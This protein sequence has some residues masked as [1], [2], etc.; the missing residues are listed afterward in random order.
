MASTHYS[1]RFFTNQTNAYR[2]H[3]RAKKTNI[4]IHICIT[5]LHP[6]EGGRG[7][8]T[9]KIK[10]Y[11]HRGIHIPILTNKSTLGILCT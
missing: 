7:G 6:L 11:I 8:V 10:C 5:S 2:S 3:E 1:A 9:L 4:Q